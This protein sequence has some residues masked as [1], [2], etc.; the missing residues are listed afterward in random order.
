MKND[1]YR[2]NVGDV[3]RDPLTGE[4]RPA[5]QVIRA[6]DLHCFTDGAC[7]RGSSAERNV[8]HSTA[9]HSREKTAHQR[10]QHTRLIVR[11]PKPVKGAA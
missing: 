6:E 9:G 10:R 1:T 7:Y 8:M 4:E 2:T 11:N 3:I 5:L